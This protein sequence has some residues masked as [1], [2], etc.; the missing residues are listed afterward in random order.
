MEDT[1]ITIAKNLLFYRKQSGLTQRAL[2]EKIGVSH[3]TISS[4]ENGTNSIDIDNLFK[5][6][7]ILN[8]DISTMFGVSTAPIKQDLTSAEKKLLDDYNKLNNDGKDKAAEYVSDL[9][10]IEKY[11][12]PDNLNSKLA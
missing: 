11:T 9:T 6:A 5:I 1:K 7:K 12:A 10:T 4:W 3:N 2:A 8:V